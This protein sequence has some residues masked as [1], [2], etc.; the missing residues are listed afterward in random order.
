MGHGFPTATRQVALTR[1]VY[2]R[3]LLGIVL[4]L[5]LLGT[6]ASYDDLD[7]TFPCKTDKDCPLTQ[8]C[9][10]GMCY[11]TVPN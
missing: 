5:G 4:V 8:Q 7:P 1:E 6:A 3:W 11:R 10:S 9:I 2:M